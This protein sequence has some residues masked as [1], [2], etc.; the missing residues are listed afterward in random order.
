MTGAAAAYIPGNPTAGIKI[1]V[2]YRQRFGKVLFY[3]G[4]GNLIIVR[5]FHQ[6][7]AYSRTVLTYIVVDLFHIFRR[8][9]RNPLV[10][11]P[12]LYER[13]VV[14]VG[15]FYITQLLFQ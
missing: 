6:H 15:L 1:L 12:R 9:I 3:T 4:V 8:S 5:R 13:G 11:Q 2:L 7:R 10:V 14:R